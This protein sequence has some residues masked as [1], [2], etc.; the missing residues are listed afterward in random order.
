MARTPSVVGIVLLSVTILVAALYM[1]Q[2]HMIGE[3]F[4][5]TNLNKKSTQY[6]NAN[7]KT[8]LIFLVFAVVISIP[9]LFAM[10]I[11][12]PNLWMLTA[13]K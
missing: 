10:M 3:P 6:F 4:S 1:K 5:V 11:W 2:S 8:F 13:F 7:P 12:F 9:F